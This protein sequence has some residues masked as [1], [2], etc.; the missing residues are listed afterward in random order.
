MRGVTIWRKL[1]DVEQVQVLGMTLQEDAGAPALVSRCGRRRAPAVG[2][3]SACGGVL[4]MTRAAACA[5]GGRWIMGRR[6]CLCR[7]QR[8]G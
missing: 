5:G 6:W 4:G 2:A 3:A 7:P 8:R 1:L